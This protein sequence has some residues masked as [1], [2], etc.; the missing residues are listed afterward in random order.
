MVG[1]R[2]R[3]DEVIIAAVNLLDIVLRVVAAVKDQGDVFA[4]LGELTIPRHKPLGDAAKHGSVVLIARRLT[5]AIITL[6]R[7]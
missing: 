2:N 4:A 1:Q 3:R 7:R 5:A 6:S